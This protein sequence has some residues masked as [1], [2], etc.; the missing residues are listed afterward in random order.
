MI[1]R[2]SQKQPFSLFVRKTWHHGDIGRMVP[3]TTRS[4]PASGEVR[5]IVE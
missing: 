1:N 5:V 2:L 4:E 3:A